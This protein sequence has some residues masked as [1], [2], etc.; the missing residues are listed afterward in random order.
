MK[1]AILISFLTSLLTVANAWVSMSAVQ[2]KSTPLKVKFANALISSLFNV[3]PLYNMARNKARKSMVER[4]LQ[5]DV[6]WSQ[7]VT[8]L[9]SSMELL[10][11]NYESLDR[12]SVNYPEYYK[13]PF[14][15][16][17]EG[18]LCW[19]AAFE[20]EPAALT[21]HASIFTP[22]ACIPITRILY[23]VFSV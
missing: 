15:A 11:K 23:I 13:R 3:K 5:I 8:H 10:K 17:E 16:Y 22:G 19:Q 4:G 12:A 18:N 14:H 7:E 2:A 9:E 20:F 1:V 6:D 21:V